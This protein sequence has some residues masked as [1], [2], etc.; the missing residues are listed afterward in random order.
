VRPPKKR[1]PAKRSGKRVA[2]RRK[3]PSRW[4]WLFLGIEVLA[5]L[6]TGLVM[7]TAVV[8]QLATTFSGSDPWRNLLPF[9][10][11]VLGLV[12]VVAVAAVLWL[13]LRRRL[14]AMIRWLPAALAFVA[15]AGAAW[16]ATEPRFHSQLQG[17]RLFMGGAAE[18]ERN[19]IAHQVY[20]AYRRADT[21]Q[22]L[23]IL[24]RS[25]VYEPAIQEAAAA[26]GVD[27]EVMIG[28]AATESSFYPRDSRDGGRGL[29]QITAPPRIAE[30]LSR[31]R[32]RVERLDPL[33]QRH[34][35]FVA[36]ATFRHYLAEMR[37]DLFLALL[38]YNIGPKNGGLRSIMQ[39][40]GAR[41][42]V[43]IQPYLQNLPRDYPIRVLS[44]A[45]ACRLWRRSGTLPRYEEGDNARHIQQIGIPGFDGR[46]TP[47]LRVA[48]TKYSDSTWVE[49]T[50]Q[51]AR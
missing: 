14:Q 21:G 37:G 2:K 6:S 25:R 24:E 13:H 12:L 36:A 40:Y 16:F 29:F 22:L 18:A 3:P 30:E 39:Q 31:Q 42:F 32:L 8:G 35:A 34:N 38:A 26:F 15:A 11:S 51:P 41:D 1:S 49:T 19:T 48:V 10:V 20:A 23:Q 45:L 9:A 46:S 5:L 44:A 43:T 27:A 4:P 33:N 7:V 47:S 17:L 50:P 28:I